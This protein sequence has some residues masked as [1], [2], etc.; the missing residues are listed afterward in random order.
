MPKCDR[1]A[2]LGCHGRIFPCLPALRV[3]GAAV[4][5]I[6]ADIEADRMRARYGRWACLRGKAVG[7]RNSGDQGLA[8]RSA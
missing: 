8:L 4:E 6:Y 7:R 5:E 3:E 1:P 2:A